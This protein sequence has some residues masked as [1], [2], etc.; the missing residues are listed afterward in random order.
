MSETKFHTHTEPQANIS[1]YINIIFHATGYV[2]I[3]NIIFIFASNSTDSDCGFLSYD[4]SVFTNVPK[5]IS[6]S[7]FIPFPGL[8][9]EDGGTSFSE[10]LV[11]TYETSRCRKSQYSQPNAAEVNILKTVSERN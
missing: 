3:S 5:G 8:Y 2:I 10:T 6:I 7:T 9:H 4:D 11:T 1:M